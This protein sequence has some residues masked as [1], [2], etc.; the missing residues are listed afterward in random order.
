MKYNIQR[1]QLLKPLQLVNGV[2]ERRQTL[3]I[4]G[5]VLLSA[6]DDQLFLTGTDL[7]VELSGQANL[8]SL[9][10]ENLQV[11]LEETAQIASENIVS[12]KDAMIHVQDML[13]RFA[14]I[15]ESEFDERLDDSILSAQVKNHEDVD[16]III[17]TG[18]HYDDNM[19]AVFFEEMELEKI[20]T[21]FSFSVI[22]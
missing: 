13:E 18:Q 20:I 12:E 6:N 17:H 2:V 11:L 8:A 4:L 14:G 1:N 19:S 9:S 21:L 16:E 22:Q 3:P 10:E 15:D 7:E 5:N